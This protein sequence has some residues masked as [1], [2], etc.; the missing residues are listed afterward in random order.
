M[1]THSTTLS[2]SYASWHSQAEKL[3]CFVLKGQLLLMA[4]SQQHV[5]DT[6]PDPHDPSTGLNVVPAS[7]PDP[8]DSGVNSPN[9]ATTNTAATVLQNAINSSHSVLSMDLNDAYYAVPTTQVTGTADQLMGGAPQTQ[10]TGIPAGSLVFGN[11]LSQHHQLPGDSFGAIITISPHNQ[12]LQWTEG[13]INVITNCYSNLTPDDAIVL[14]SRMLSGDQ[15][16]DVPGVTEG[17]LHGLPSNFAATHSWLLSPLVQLCFWQLLNPD[18]ASVRTPRERKLITLLGRQSENLNLLFGRIRDVGAQILAG[19]DDDNLQH[20]QSVVGPIT[21]EYVSAQNQELLLDLLGLTLYVAD[22]PAGAFMGRDLLN[23]ELALY[24]LVNA[25]RPIP[26]HRFRWPAT[27]AP[28]RQIAAR[29]RSRSRVRSPRANRVTFNDAV[30]PVSPP[31]QVEGPPLMPQAP[32]HGNLSNSSAPQPLVE[33]V[34]NSMQSPAPQLVAT[35]VAHAQPANS[36]PANQVTSADTMPQNQA[37]FCTGLPGAPVYHF[38]VVGSVVTGFDGLPRVVE[39]NS[40]SSNT[41]IAPPG[42]VEPP[43]EARQSCSGNF[44]RYWDFNVGRWAY[45]PSPPANGLRPSSAEDFGDGNTGLNGPGYQTFS[46]PAN[47][48]DTYQPS[49]ATSFAAQQDNWWNNGNAYS[50]GSWNNWN[51]GFGSNWNR[52]Q[53]SGMNG[54]GNTEMFPWDTP[55]IHSVLEPTWAPSE[56]A[57]T[58]LFSPV[59]DA[60]ALLKGGLPVLDAIDAGASIS[61]AKNYLIAPVFRYVLR[62]SFTF[63][64]KRSCLEPIMGEPRVAPRA[65]ITD[66]L[67]LLFQS[68]SWLEEIA[69]QNPEFVNGTTDVQRHALAQLCGSTVLEQD[70]INNLWNQVAAPLSSLHGGLV[71]ALTTCLL[72]KT[73]PR[74]ADLRAKGDFIMPFGK[75]SKGDELA[76]AFTILQSKAPAEDFLSIT[77]LYYK[78]GGLSDSERGRLSRVVQKIKKVIQQTR[79]QFSGGI[80]D[81]SVIWNDVQVKEISND[82]GPVDLALLVLKIVRPDNACISDMRATLARVLNGCNLSAKSYESQTKI[83]V[84][85]FSK[86][87]N[88]LGNWPHLSEMGENVRRATFDFPDYVKKVTQPD[89]SNNSSYNYN[90]GGKKNANNNNTSTPATNPNKIK[91]PKENFE[92]GDDLRVFVGKTYGLANEHL[93]SISQEERDKIETDNAASNLKIKWDDAKSKWRLDCGKACA[94]AVIC[95]KCPLQGCKKQHPEKVVKLL[96]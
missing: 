61:K 68:F 29:N 36:L 51:S 69:T 60:C 86:G 42:V 92:A 82:F 34:D 95:G 32:A 93:A 39:P 8:D 54:G 11:T 46:G 33:G 64:V 30:S 75:S 58:M 12:V 48:P 87:P 43:T 94:L 47:R 79:T 14:L 85:S 18:G 73:S 35:S 3:H 22:Y 13:T 63:F 26:S 78:A 49:H 59:T 90:Y 9:Y 10:S 25:P 23:L 91:I 41:G 66:T 24:Q 38:P 52:H 19:L 56:P 15:P 6:Q 21:P 37:T 57:Y 81:P 83:I 71:Y 1:L 44:T 5:P 62:I 16:Y 7:H 50:G 77:S 27:R 96:P 67:P 2:L 45:V 80:D 40:L 88:N 20:L 31:N 53:N 84:L 89:N 70:Q 55:E 4:S 17:P 74:A 76:S 65:R 72:N 28:A